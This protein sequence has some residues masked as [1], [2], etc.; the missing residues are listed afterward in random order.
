D[1]V[2]DGIV[3]SEEFWAVHAP[4]YMNKKPAQNQ[5]VGVESGFLSGIKPQT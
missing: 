3:T 4:Q 1:L 5:D 2:T